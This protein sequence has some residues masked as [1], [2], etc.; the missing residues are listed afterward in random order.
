[1]IPTRRPNLANAHTVAAIVSA[2]TITQAGTFPSGPP[3]RL[4]EHCCWPGRTIR[5]ADGA[6]PDPA[7]AFAGRTGGDDV[8]VPDVPL[9]VFVWV[10]LI[11]M[12]PRS[13]HC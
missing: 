12:H 13:Q 3:R 4:F 9:A 11:R 8:V 5:V 2:S 10:A 6:A 7:G 1:M